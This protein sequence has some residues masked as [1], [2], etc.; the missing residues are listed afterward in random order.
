MTTQDIENLLSGLKKDIP[1][2]SDWENMEGFI[3]SAEPF[4]D[5]TIATTTGASWGVQTGDIL[6]SGEARKYQK[7]LTVRLFDDSN[8]AFMAKEASAALA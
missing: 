3:E 4:L 7:R 6:F 5:V 2:Q 1:S 8:V